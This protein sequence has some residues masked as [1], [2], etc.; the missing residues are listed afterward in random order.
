MLGKH[1]AAWLLPEPQ[2][3]RITYLFLKGKMSTKG[4]ASEFPCTEAAGRGHWLPRPPPPLIR[5][6]D[7]PLSYLS[8]LSPVPLHL[9]RTTMAERGPHCSCRDEAISAAEHS[10]APR[11]SVTCPRLG[12]S[13]LLARSPEY[14]PTPTF[15][16]ATVLVL[17]LECHLELLNVPWICSC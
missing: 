6:V 17:C 9:F 10:D 7:L 16:E 1:Q 8:C 15:P 2:A 11:G 4:L 3:T 5:G 12:R 13:Q 14:P